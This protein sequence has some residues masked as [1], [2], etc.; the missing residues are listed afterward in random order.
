MNRDDKQF[1]MVSA[2]IAFFIAAVTFLA[3]SAMGNYQEAR[4]ACVGAGFSFNSRSGPL[5][6]TK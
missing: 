3:W 1:A 2:T 5:E 6:C 4:M